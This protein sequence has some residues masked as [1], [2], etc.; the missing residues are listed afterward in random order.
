MYLIDYK[1]NSNNQNNTL[2][3]KFNAQ[4]CQPSPVAFASFATGGKR[5]YGNV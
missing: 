3:P 5:F 1:I 4:R 2:Y